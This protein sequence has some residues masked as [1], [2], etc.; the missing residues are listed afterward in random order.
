MAKVYNVNY[1]KNY[2][3]NDG[4]ERTMFVRVGTAFPMKDTDGFT[5]ELDVPLSMSEGS[6]LC[7]FVRDQKDE[8]R[9]NRDNRDNRGGGRR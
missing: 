1:P 5:V 3:D 6:R 2:K 8:R 4:K 7:L 9:D